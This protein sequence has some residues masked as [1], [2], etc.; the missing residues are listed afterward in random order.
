MRIAA[1]LI[2]LVIVHPASVWAKHGQFPQWVNKA[3]DG[4]GE[5]CC[6]EMDC[7]PAQAALILDEIAGYAFASIDGS[8]GFIPDYSVVRVQCP[9]E[10]P[11][12]YVCFKIGHENKISTGQIIVNENSIK[13]LLIPKCGDGTS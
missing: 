1:I 13:C 6:G 10:D 11:R 7:T 4:Q 5:S 12:P 3:V 2:F 9:M 8:T